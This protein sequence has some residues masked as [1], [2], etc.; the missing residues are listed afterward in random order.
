[1]TLVELLVT[2]SILAILGS[3]LMFAM[4][5]AT[6]A[7]RRAKTRTMI[8]TLHTL[9]MERYESYRTRRVP[10][11]T[12]NKVLYPTLQ[13]VQFARLNGI[14]ELMKIEMPDR[15][16]DI[17]LDSVKNF[18]PDTSQDFPSP[19]EAD[20]VDIDRTALSRAY[21]RRYTQ[22]TKNDPNDIQTN[23]G[24][25]CLY[26]IITMATGEGEARS[27]FADSSIG[28]VDNDGAPEFLDGWG[29]PISFL[30]WPAGFRSELQTGDPLN[31][32]DPFDP[33]KVHSAM[34]PAPDPDAY[35][36]V[37]LIY[38]A[39]PDDIFDISAPPETI[40]GL[41]PYSTPMLGT[42]RPGTDGDENW[43]DNIHNHLIG[44]R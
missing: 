32:H 13:S 10:I 12:S 29:K 44:L 6:E 3:A 5:G 42:Q 4:V 21:L 38:S 30:R 28:D 36:L 2:I 43:H 16:S 27:H 25:E 41:N 23:Q 7:A 31:D 19:L 40:T 37:P 26:M 1:M 14:R 15:W 17:V 9:L 22:L 39:G 34:Y 8:A 35:R 11:D 24:A 18:L 20:D 33:L